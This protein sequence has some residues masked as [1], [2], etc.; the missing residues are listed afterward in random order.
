[1][2]RCI[3]AIAKTIM[4]IPPTSTRMVLICGVTSAEVGTLDKANPA[5][6]AARYKPTIL[7]HTKIPPSTVFY[8]E[9]GRL[10]RN[11]YIK[12]VD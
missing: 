7:S 2:A 6:I 4:T 3:I 5:K 10:V 12:L 1:M 11:N 9:G 8:A